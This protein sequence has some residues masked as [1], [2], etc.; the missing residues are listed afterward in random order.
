VQKNG[1]QLKLY[2]GFVMKKFINRPEDVV[3]EMLKVIVRTDSE[4]ARAQQVAVLSGGGSA[5]LR[6]TLVSVSIREDH[7]ETILV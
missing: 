7:E 6:S 1:L 5:A 3:E 4:Q 2:I